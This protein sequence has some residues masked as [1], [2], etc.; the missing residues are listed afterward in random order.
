MNNGKAIFGKLVGDPALI[1]ANKT[2]SAPEV[3]HDVDAVALTGIVGRGGV[4]HCVRPSPVVARARGAPSTRS[5]PSGRMRPMQFW[6]R[7]LLRGLKP[8]L[9]EGAQILAVEHGTSDALGEVRKVTAV[10][11]DGALLLAT[12]ARAKT[13]LTTVPRPDIRSVEVLAVNYVAIDYED[14]ER[15]IRRVIKLDLRRSGDRAGLVARLN[16]V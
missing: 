8:H 4:T 2:G 11:T 3:T 5:R 9:P 16:P 7:L 13:V 14:F 1:A 10:L 12:S 15:A 6:D